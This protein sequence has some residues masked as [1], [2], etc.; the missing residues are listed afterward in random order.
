[1]KSRLLSREHDEG[2]V[3]L[4][5]IVDQAARPAEVLNLLLSEVGICSRG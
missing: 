1:M 3:N 5:G 2:T 4:A